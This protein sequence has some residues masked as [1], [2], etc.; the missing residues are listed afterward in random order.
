MILHVKSR[1]IRVARRLRKL[2]YAPSF[3]SAI[4]LAMQD[5]GFCFLEIREL[6]PTM[7]KSAGINFRVTKRMAEFMR[8]CYYNRKVRPTRFRLTMR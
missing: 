6:E 1:H 4:A 8:K 7:V 3:N 2:G 5:V